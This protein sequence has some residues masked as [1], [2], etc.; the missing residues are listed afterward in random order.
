MAEQLCTGAVGE[1]RK[2][3]GSPKYGPWPNIFIPIRAS[4]KAA[5]RGDA[6]AFASAEKSRACHFASYASGLN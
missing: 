3:L 6:I 4:P 5:D 1:K 2:R